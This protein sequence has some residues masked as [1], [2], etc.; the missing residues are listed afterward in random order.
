MGGLKEVVVKLIIRLLAFCSFLAFAVVPAQAQKQ[1]EISASAGAITGIYDGTYRCARGPVNLRLT[2]VAPGDGSLSG[3]FTFDLP[4]N[5]S[6][7]TASYTLRGT[8]NAATGKFRLD[9]DKWEPPEP[10]NYVMVG[11]DGEFNFSKEQVA[12]KITAGYGACTTFE[13][14]RNKAESAS[15]P[16]HP[17]V[18]PTA[19]AAQQPRSSST[20]SPPGQNGSAQKQ[21]G[22]GWWWYCTAGPYMTGVF[23]YP[24]DI[25]TRA[26][27]DAAIQTAWSS[28]VTREYPNQNLATGCT[29][30]GTEQ[31]STQRIHDHMRASQKVVDVDWKYVPGQD[32][33]T[34][35]SQRTGAQTIAASR[36]QT[37]QHPATAAVTSNAYGTTLKCLSAKSDVPNPQTE[38][39]CHVV[40]P[41]LKVDLKVGSVVNF[42]RTGTVTLTCSG[43]GN[44]VD[45]TA[46]VEPRNARNSK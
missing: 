24:A 11:M 4:A 13:A 40:G 31:A 17:A 44:R 38:P 35:A 45:C 19:L 33:P 1:Q 21:Q 7:R 12:G 18:T 10:A 5:S 28:H 26:D 25:T 3:V 34:V 46:G 30:G 9:P 23:F 14:T 27:V 42:N 36:D 22:G 39:S 29:L 37:G 32:G 41:D 8:Y 6:N 20:A 15:L 2:L 43:Q 16:H